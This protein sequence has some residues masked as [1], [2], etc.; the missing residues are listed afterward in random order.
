MDPSPNLNQTGHNHQPGYEEIDVSPRPIF[1]FLGVLIA[2]AVVI[3]LL[4]FAQLRWFAGQETPAAGKVGPLP[5]LARQPTAEPRLQEAYAIDLE[6]MRRRER[7]ELGSSGWVDEKAG[8]VRIPIDEAMRVIA[9]GGLPARKSQEGA[10]GAV[11]QPK[12]SDDR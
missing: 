10:A 8:T 6:V 3:H 7:A 4:L 11:A 5:P 2:S 9:E 12:N 1:Y